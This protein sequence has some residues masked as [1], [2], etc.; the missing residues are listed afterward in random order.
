[1]FMWVV[2]ISIISF[3]YMLIYILFLSLIWWFSIPWIYLVKVLVFIY[4]KRYSY[5]LPFSVPLFKYIVICFS[6]FSSLAFCSAS[7]SG[8]LLFDFCLSSKSWN[9]FTCSMRLVSFL[10]STVGKFALALF[11]S[12]SRRAS[13]S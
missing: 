6:H 3:E 10:S 5:I 2:I 9:K 7:C 8:L 11:L 12:K 1:M 13:L 4:T